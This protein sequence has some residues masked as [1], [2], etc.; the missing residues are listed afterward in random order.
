M[1]HEPRP[2]TTRK[3]TSHSTNIKHTI[4]IGHQTKPITIGKNNIE[5]KDK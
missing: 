5:F 1:G 2:T 4:Q 3:T